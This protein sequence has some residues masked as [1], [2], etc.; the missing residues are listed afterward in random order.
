M[1]PGMSVSYVARRALA[2]DASPR[3]EYFFTHGQPS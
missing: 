2:W 1:Q 3:L